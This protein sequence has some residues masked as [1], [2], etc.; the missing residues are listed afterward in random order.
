MELVLLIFSKGE[1][2]MLLLVVVK[3][4]LGG[5]LFWLLL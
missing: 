4:E 5:F 2:V 1:E 3:E